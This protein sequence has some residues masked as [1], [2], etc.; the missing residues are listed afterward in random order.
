MP[1]DYEVKYVFVQ[2][3]I[4]HVGKKYFDSLSEARFFL[5]NQGTLATHLGSTR[6]HKIKYTPSLGDIYYPALQWFW[7]T[8]V[9]GQYSTLTSEL[10]FNTE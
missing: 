9:K 7:D 10:W 2:E 8:T 5:K 6:P 1:N 4:F 3:G